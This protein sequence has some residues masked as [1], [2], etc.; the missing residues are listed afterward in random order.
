MEMFEAYPARA[1]PGQWIRA[2]TGMPEE[3]LFMI[4]I[5]IPPRSEMASLPV[6]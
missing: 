4:V 5:E 2:G 3:E 1:E 6:W